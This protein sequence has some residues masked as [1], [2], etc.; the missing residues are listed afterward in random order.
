MRVIK[1]LMHYGLAKYRRNRWRSREE[2]EAWQ[3]LKVKSFL[4]GIRRKSKFYG[5]YYKDLPLDNWRI[6]KTTNKAIMMEQ[7]DLLNTAGITKK[8]A[9]EIAI[10]AERERDFSSQLKGVTV[11]LSSGTS[12][13]RGIFLV[14]EE[15][16][17]A[18][19]G[20][21]LAK[22]L[23]GSLLSKH[24]IAFFLRADS[25]L[26]QTVHSRRLQ[27][28]FYDMIKPLQEQIEKLNLLQPTILVAPPSMLRFLSEAK[29]QGT[30]L[31]APIKVISVAEVLEPIDK[32]YIEE[33]FQ[34]SLHQVYQCTEG[35]LAAS[36][37]HGT[38]HLNEDILVIQREYIDATR[39]IFTPIITDF[40]RLTQPIIRY[41]LNDMLTESEKPCPCG[42]VFTA[43]ESV[44]GRMDDLFFGL[45]DQTNHRIPIFPDFI[46]RAVMMSSDRILEYKIVQLSETELVAALR[47]DGEEESVKDALTG[48]LR[49]L[50]AE[51][52]CKAAHVRFV[53]YR[54]QSGLQKLRRI[55]R[56]YAV[57]S[58]G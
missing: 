19:A 11:G 17:A 7:F 47:I 10:R 22:V 56:R 6:W 23:P 24:R 4:K 41:R 35:F 21:V 34:T 18:W 27:F 36:C 20:T 5:Q 30:L 42:S 12:G 53:P 43:I 40:S 39:R 26:Y 46:R 9:F 54:S 44:G 55:E 2:L 51:I 8:E 28:Q 49:S 13:N 32:R 48:Q 38:L 14:S 33:A 57:E 52:Q 31:I 45:H 1:L 16:R 15:E 25:N 58:G 37:E 29:L 50:F 3:Q